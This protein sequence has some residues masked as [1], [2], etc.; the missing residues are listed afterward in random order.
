MKVKVVQMVGDELQAKVLQ[1]ENAQGLA[2]VMA[3][4]GF[5]F[6]HHNSN[7]RHEAALRGLPV[8][9]D[10]YGPVYESEGVVRY[11]DEAADAFLSD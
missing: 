7:K 4:L 8:F 10:L 3:G 1:V 2:D 6:S 9:A 5:E 11:H